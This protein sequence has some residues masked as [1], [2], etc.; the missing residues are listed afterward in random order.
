MISKPL[1]RAFAT[2][3]AATS[4]SAPVTTIPPNQAL[5]RTPGRGGVV[6]P[7]ALVEA[8]RRLTLSVRLQFTS[9]LD[10]QFC[11]HGGCLDKR[12]EV[13]SLNVGE[14][15]QCRTYAYRW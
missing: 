13:T 3:G 12:K 10:E 8:R 14:F 1:R 11:T 5:K 4:A 9:D 7:R 6:S 15:L 2:V